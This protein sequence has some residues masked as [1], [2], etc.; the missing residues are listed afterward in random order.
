MKER[1]TTGIFG[2]TKRKGQFFILS[3]VIML[4]VLYSISR[5]LNSN[6]KTDVSEVQGNDAA[7]ALNNIANGI[8]RTMNFS[9]QSN[10]EENLYTFILSEKGAIGDTYS[11]DYFFNI[12]YPNV[13]A[14]ITL[15]SRTFFVNKEM[16]FE[17]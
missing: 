6:W 7:E 12:T 15:S 8:N 4:L 10:L 13:T 11:L 5:T 1:N 14:N 16:R 2:E 9:D 3:A 17:R